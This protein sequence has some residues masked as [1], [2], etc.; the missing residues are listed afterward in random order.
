[1][2]T[3]TRRIRRQSLY[4][5]IEN[6]RDVGVKLPKGVLQQVEECLLINTVVVFHT[7]LGILLPET[8]T[9]LHVLLPLLLV[10]TTLW[11][12]E[13]PYSIMSSSS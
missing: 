6:S 3:Y 13:E 12:P 5:I 10:A 4:S 9:R 7:V 1:M 2:L 11:L 8:V